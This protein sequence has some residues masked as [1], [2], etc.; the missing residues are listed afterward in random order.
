MVLPLDAE[1]NLRYWPSSETFNYIDGTD[2]WP[3]DFEILITPP[4]PNKLP[5]MQQVL[6][7]EGATIREADEIFVIG[8]SLPSTD[9]DQWDLIREAVSARATAVPALTIVNHSAPPEYFD[10]LCG[11]FQPLTTRTFNA[12]FADFAL[13]M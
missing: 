1:L 9:G 5:I 10:D 2:A 7:R 3:G 4:S 13:Q 6:A 12:G 11:L 8:Y